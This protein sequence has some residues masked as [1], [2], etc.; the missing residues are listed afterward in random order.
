MP[1]QPVRSLDTNGIYRAITVTHTGD[2]RGDTWNTHI[3]AITQAGLLPNMN[4]NSAVYN[5]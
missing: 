1:G 2:T 3:E 4:A 5:W